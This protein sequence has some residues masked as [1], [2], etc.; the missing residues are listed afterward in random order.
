M[1]QINNLP[2]YAIATSMVSSLGDKVSAHWEAVKAKQSGIRLYQDYAYGK[3][4][5][6]SSRIHQA[7]W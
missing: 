4:P 5:F 1:A 6:W 7:I 3:E 2:V